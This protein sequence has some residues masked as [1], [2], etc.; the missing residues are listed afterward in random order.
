MSKKRLGKGL[1]ALIPELKEEPTK[2]QSEQREELPIEQLEPNPHQPR[3]EFSD[4]ALEE[5]ANSIKA[6]GVIQP[7]IVVPQGNKYVIVAGER[8][9]RAAKQADLATIPAIIKDF[10][11]TQMMQIALLENI[12]REDLNPIDKGE[13]LKKLI[14][15]HGLTQNQ[16][17]KELGIGR[18]SLANILR[19]LQLEPK[20]SNMVRKGVLT[21]G[22][23]RALLSL[24]GDEQIQL[25]E[26]I[27]Q[28]GFSVRETEKKVKDLLKKDKEKPKRDSSKDPFINDIEE[29]LA[30]RLGTKVQINKGK[31]KGKIEI[32]FI[33]NDDLE[34]L[35]ELLSK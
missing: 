7:I 21:E 6:H 23:A 2:E 8:R 17:S 11:E 12:Q 15:E 22:H 3:K 27:S 4:E 35:I 5:L 33:S 26:E 20:V 19:I 28:K 16:L 9:Y 34:K 14:D 24:K 29:K 18:S 31:K 10:S 1:D 32:E 30:Q 25:A 13:A